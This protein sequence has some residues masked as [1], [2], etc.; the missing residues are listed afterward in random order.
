MSK[1]LIIALSIGLVTLLV[2]WVV[3][4]P[5]GE[6]L[7]TEIVEAWSRYRSEL[8]AP[9]QIAGKRHNVAPFEILIN[10]EHVLYK[11]ARVGKRIDIIEGYNG[12]SKFSY[13]L[14][15]EEWKVGVGP[16]SAK[17]RQNQLLSSL[18]RH[19]SNEVFAL[20]TINGRPLDEMIKNREV[21]IVSVKEKT[22][23][24]NEIVEMTCKDRRIGQ[25][26]FTVTLDPKR[27]WTIESYTYRDGSREL[28]KQFETVDFG[29][30]PVAATETIVDRRLIEGGPMSATIIERVYHR[31]GV[32]DFER[33]FNDSAKIVD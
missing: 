29:G 16:H 27:F 21:R 8:S 19:A 22:K 4:N 25:V 6:A 5:T 1:K 3:L 28:S 20:L 10:G 11:N 32:E 17:E 12:V 9:M 18:A 13:Q 7:D 24:G 33:S 14:E 15:N 26:S 31:I 23:N 2:A 30:V